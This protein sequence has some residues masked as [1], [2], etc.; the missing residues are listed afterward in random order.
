MA[1]GLRRFRV[2]RN[3]TTTIEG[4]IWSDGAATIRVNGGAPTNWTAAQVE[5][6]RHPTD[7]SASDVQ[8]DDSD[9]PPVDSPPA[10]PCDAPTP[11]PHDL[12]RHRYR[13]DG[14]RDCLDDDWCR[15]PAPAATGGT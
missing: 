11:C 15:A 6:R 9:D 4:V 3:G 12:S 7:G 14:S 2:V 13:P 1:A 10:Q 8:L 5:A